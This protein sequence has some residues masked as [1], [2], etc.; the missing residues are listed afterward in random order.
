MSLT[1][2][3]QTEKISIRLWPAEDLAADSAGAIVTGHMQK[4]MSLA[5][6]VARTNVSVLITGGIDPQSATSNRGCRRRT[7]SRACPIA[8]CKQPAALLSHRL[9]DHAGGPTVLKFLSH[10]RGLL[11]QDAHE[12]PDLVPS[13]HPGIT[14]SR[15]RSGSREVRHSSVQTNQISLSPVGERGGQ[16][17]WGYPHFHSRR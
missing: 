11:V 7:G 10:A 8:R 2:L 1:A 5:Q 6:R 15:W 4:L 14:A 16:R 3:A 13:T 9:H 12:V 17:R